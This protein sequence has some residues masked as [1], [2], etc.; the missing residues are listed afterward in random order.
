MVGV[1]LPVRGAPLQMI[2]TEPAPT[3]VTQLVAHADRHLSLKQAG[4]GGLIVGG[5][6]SAAADPATG[7]AR[8]LRA[9]IEGNLWVARRVLPALDGLHV[10]RTWAAMNVNIDGAPILGP[11]PGAPGFFNAVTSNGYT[12]APVVGRLTAELIAR[13]R[14]S[15]PIERYALSRFG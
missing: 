11:A 7:F 3:L 6:W 2:V 14:A 1:K 4:A 8:T 10:I 9:S 5:G 15:L 13:G 12:L